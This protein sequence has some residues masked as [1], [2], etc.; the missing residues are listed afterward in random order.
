MLEDRILIWKARRGD[1]LAFDRI[2]HRYLDYEFLI[3]EGPKDRC[4][5]REFKQVKTTERPDS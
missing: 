2:Y 3:N 5:I 1:R 4:R